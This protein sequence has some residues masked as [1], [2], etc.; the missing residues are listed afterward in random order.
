MG[1]IG[2]AF[3]LVLHYRPNGGGYMNVIGTCTWGNIH[4]SALNLLR[5]YFVLPESP[6]ENDRT[7]DLIFKVVFGYCIRTQKPVICELL[8]I[9]FIFIA[10]FMI[11][12]CRLH[13]SGKKMGLT[14]VQMGNTFAFIGL[15]TVI[16]RGLVEGWY[17]SLGNSG[18]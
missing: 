11:R 13:C 5:F 9:N 4:L 8:A 17:G 14:D 3:G 7:R 12:K 6:K 10:S 2:A 18:C 15:A 16:V 1:F